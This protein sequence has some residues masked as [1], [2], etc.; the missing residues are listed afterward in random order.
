MAVIAEACFQSDR[1][2]GAIGFNEELA[3]LSNPELAQ[4]FCRT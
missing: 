4:V 3:R 2:N 1:G